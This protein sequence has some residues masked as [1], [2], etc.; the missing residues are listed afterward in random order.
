[1]RVGWVTLPLLCLAL[2]CAWAEPLR[3]GADV[4]EIKVAGWLNG[5]APTAEERKGKVQV[6]D[7]WGYW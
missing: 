6:I 7:F 5:S 4:P 1:M 3:P 2:L